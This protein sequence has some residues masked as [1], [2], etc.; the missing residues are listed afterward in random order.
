MTH[1]PEAAWP[2]TST[3]TGYYPDPNP[4][5]AVPPSNLMPLDSTRFGRFR[6]SQKIPVRAAPH[7]VRIAMLAIILGTAI[8]LTAIAG[9]MFSLA[10][11]IVTWVGLILVAS[12]ALGGPGK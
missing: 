10:G 11:I 6:A 4:A 7:G 9:S 8:P 2:L 5:P 1:D 3:E 12:F